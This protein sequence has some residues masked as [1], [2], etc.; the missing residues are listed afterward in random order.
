MVARPRDKY[1][2]YCPPPGGGFQYSETS[3]AT[4]STS[5]ARHFQEKGCREPRQSQKTGREPGRVV[6]ADRIAC[7]GGYHSLDTT[8]KES[9]YPI[10]LAQQTRPEMVART[11]ATQEEAAKHESA[12]A[13]VISLKK[14]DLKQEQKRRARCKHVSEHKINSQSYYRFC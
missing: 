2:T 3:G 4:I 7:P 11:S 10:Q 14:R 5:T 13:F 8:Q 6:A 1:G 12:S 9:A